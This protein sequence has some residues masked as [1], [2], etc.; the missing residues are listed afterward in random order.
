MHIRYNTS[1][2]CLH[3]SRPQFSPLKSHFYMFAGYV[4]PL[5]AHTG[6]CFVYHLIAMLKCFP[7]CVSQRKSIFERFSP[8]YVNIIQNSIS[9]YIATWV[10]TVAKV[11]R[12]TFAVTKR[13]RIEGQQIG[14][15]LRESLSRNKPFPSLQHDLK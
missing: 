2:K 15:S 1:S 11:L 13:G 6:K 12:R 3:I 9:F 4:L 14:F 5:A 10:R 8:H 7:K